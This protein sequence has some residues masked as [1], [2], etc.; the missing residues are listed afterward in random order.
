VTVVSFSAG[1]LAPVV[2]PI[3]TTFDRQRNKR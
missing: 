2:Q 3:A 1:K